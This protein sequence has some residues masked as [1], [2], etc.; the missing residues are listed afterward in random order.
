MFERLRRAPGRTAISVGIA[1]TFGLALGIL[2]VPFGPSPGDASAPLPKT[3]LLGRELLP[4]DQANKV[5]LSRVRG[6]L[7]SRFVLE[8]PDGGRR[9]IYL[10]ELGAELDKVHLAALTREA[11][12]QTSA[13]VRAF[14]STGSQAPLAL[15]VPVGLNRELALK[16]LRA[17][18]D[19][20]DRLPV[21]ARLDLDNRSVV[22]ETVGRLLDLDASL[23][24]IE[25][26]LEQGQRSAKLAFFE[27]K[28]RRL[29]SE[30]GAVEFGDVLGFFET[31][32]DRSERY[33]AR[34]YNLRLAASKIDGYVLLPGEVFD[35]NQVVGPRDEASGYKVASVIA[36]GELVDGIGGGT[37]QISGTLHGAAFFA[38]L[39]IVERYP[40]TRPSGY[41]KLGLDATVVYP[42]INFRVRNPFDVPVVLRETVKNGVVRA[43]VLGPKRR[44]TVTLIRRILDSMPYEEV[45]RP[46]PE[47]PRGARVLGQRGVPGFKLRRYRI[48]R[49][50]AHAIRDRW[51]DVYP[52]TTQIIRVGAKDTSG[53]EPVPKDDP[54]PEYLADELLMVTQGPESEEG[55]RG[56]EIESRE[57]GR[58]GTAGWTEAA[59]MPYFQTREETAGGPRD[60][61]PKSKDKPGKRRAGI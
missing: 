50:G 41:I 39:Q 3:H 15:P 53:D 29:S 47:L 35:F 16:R 11:R 44:H 52:P 14:E 26:A 13:L 19:E 42:T 45:E 8:L 28:P 6:Y 17:L 1:V 34:T 37:C 4:D 20:L 10:G 46:D 40:H 7:S 22:K 18:K 38:G 49:D 21:D 43:E 54:H 57:P 31:R 48:V 25:A 9:E 5:A 27:R 12:D 24:A 2:L 23:L 56:A 59:G 60:K 33:E 36:Q 32:Y 51:D 30:L 58:F 61:P 55:E